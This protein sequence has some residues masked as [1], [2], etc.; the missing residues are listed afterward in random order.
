V[1]FE[2]AG[3]AVDRELARLTDYFENT[4]RPKTRE[5]LAELLRKAAARLAKL[6]DEVEKSEP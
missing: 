1:N 4:V 5:G 2:E 6:A 3:R